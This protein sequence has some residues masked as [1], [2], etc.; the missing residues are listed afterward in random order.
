MPICRPKMKNRKRSHCRKSGKAMGMLKAA[1]RGAVKPD[2][3]GL[4]FFEQL[5]AAGLVQCVLLNRAFFQ[6]T[7]GDPE[8][9]KKNQEE[10][11]HDREEN[12]ITVQHP[13]PVV[14]TVSQGIEPPDVHQV[15]NAHDPGQDRHHSQKNRGND[16]RHQTYGPFFPGTAWIFHWAFHF[17]REDKKHAF[18][19]S[20]SSQN[21]SGPAPPVGE[22]DGAP[23]R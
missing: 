20:V 22:P 9:E 11:Q 19:S 21:N 4:K 1:D 16:A 18:Q 13:L 17:P 15:V 6:K 23:S 7:G 8:V 5:A 14:K 3:T 2:R 10:C 12:R